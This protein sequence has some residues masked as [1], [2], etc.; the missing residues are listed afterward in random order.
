M[1]RMRIALVAVAL[2]ALACRGGS[3]PV[4]ETRSQPEGAS[5]HDRCCAECASAA[6]RDPTGADLRGKPCTAYPVEWSG[7]PG[8]SDACRGWFVARPEPT[9]VGDCQRRPAP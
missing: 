5:M 6:S 2:A 7:G 3:P 8:V 4:P 9:L 1:G